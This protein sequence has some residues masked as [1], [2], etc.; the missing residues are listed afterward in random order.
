MRATGRVTAAAALAAAL[1]LSP[2][3]AAA[4]AVGPAPCV[5]GESEA[6]GDSSVDG[7]E[8]RWEDDSKYNDPLK[9]AHKVWSLGLVKIAPDGAGSVNDLEWRDYSKADG[10]A[11][12]WQGKPG[13]D[14]IYLNSYYL[15]GRYKDR[16]SRRHVA[17][18]ELGHALGMCHK[19]DTWAS[20]MWTKV[21]DN[22]PTEPT[23]RDE[24]NYRKLWK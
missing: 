9:W 14:Y 23:H 4:A 15:D 10:H 11:G 18:H 19:P 12:Y 8:L 21:V 16:A 22:P 6:R 3:G 13:V 2:H 5:R 24:A 7:K 17:V 20:V 1:L